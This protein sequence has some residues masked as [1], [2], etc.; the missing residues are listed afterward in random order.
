MVSLLRVA[1]VW[2]TVLSVS[3]AWTIP[4]ASVIRSLSKRAI[5]LWHNVSPPSPAAFSQDE[6]D[7]LNDWLSDSITMARTAR[8]ML[9]RYSSDRV[10]AATLGTFLGVEPID[11]NGQFTPKDP[12]QLQN[13]KG[14]DWLGDVVAYAEGG[15]ASFGYSEAWL[16]KGDSF[17]QRKT[18]DDWVQ[19]DDGSVAKFEQNGV[20]QPISLRQVADFAGEIAKGRWIWWIPGMG[21]YLSL[22]AGDF[23]PG[24]PG[25][26]P[27]SQCTGA[28]AFTGTTRG[29]QGVRKSLITI[30]KPG[31]QGDGTP[32]DHFSAIP[33]KMF[34]DV[35][36]TKDAVVEKHF[37]RSTILLHEMMHAVRQGKSPDLVNGSDQCFAKRKTGASAV[38]PACVTAM[39]VAMNFLDRGLT[40]GQDPW[41]FW[42]GRARAASEAY[43]WFVNQKKDQQS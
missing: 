2:A 34:A 6:V 38:S 22:G 11:D 4:H 32:V 21:S 37:S 5:S 9:D 27:G 33:Y 43:E 10:V 14:P 26:S 23:T 16:M 35:P 42:T 24:V 25:V 20:E 1:L 36:V 41:S 40:A 39:V 19:Q 17:Q 30:C 15:F 18:L 28:G 7:E 8:R 13:F 31:A 3:L 12:A 29:L